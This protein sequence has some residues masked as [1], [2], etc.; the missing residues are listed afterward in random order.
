MSK[1]YFN[2]K[3]LFSII[4]VN[5][6]FSQQGCTDPL[7]NNYN[8]NALSNNG[9]CTYNTTNLSILQSL[10]LSNTIS[11][12]S[13][14]IEWDNFLYTHNDDSNV[15]IYKL[16]KSTGDITT[17]HNLSGVINIDWEEISQDQNNIYIGEFGNNVSGNR[18][19]LKIYKFLKSTISNPI[20]ETINFSYS[21]QTD[22]TAQNVNNTDF[23]CE[24]FVVTENEIL[25]FTKQWITQKSTI[26]SIPKVA[27]TH[28]ATPLATINVG[29]LI[30][31]A[32][33]IE[34]YNVIVLS[35]YNST[36]SPFIYLIYDLNGLNFNQANQRK[37]DLNLS[38]HQIESISSIDGLEY[39]LTNESFAYP[40]FIESPQKLHKIS[41]NSFLGNYINSL[42]LN[43]YKFSNE[44]IFYPNPANNLLMIKNNN[45]I[46]L[47]YK[48]TNLSGQT[49]QQGIFENNQINIE[50][51]ETGIYFINIID[52]NQISKIIKN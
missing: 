21:N 37:I 39:F 35:G 50:N 14:L 30:T 18:T 24:A 12:T 16:N 11:E 28:I 3:L 8:I 20:I 52:S 34:N 32:T 23:D 2:L 29:G 4:F 13:G 25:L 7:A 22:F 47:N 44:I 43:E 6:A 46:D 33:Y 19:N 41:L 48:I 17:T 40:P 51:L 42:N 38:F 36:L 9:S 27:G 49:V 45:S 26:Y 1:F 15:N 31:G 10:P 5:N